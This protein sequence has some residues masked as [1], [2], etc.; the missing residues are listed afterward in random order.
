MSDIKPSVS[1]DPRCYTVN[2]SKAEANQKEYQRIVAG[3]LYIARTTRL[4]ILIHI[5]LLVRRTKAPSISN[6]QAAKDISQYLLLTKSKGLRI[7]GTMEDLALTVYTDI[8]Y[9]GEEA[10]LQTG[11]IITLNNQL[12][13]WYSF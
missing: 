4:E 8:S 1:I 7:R 2:E 6:L 5:N 12:V 9:G 10:Q 11:V 3:L 13:L